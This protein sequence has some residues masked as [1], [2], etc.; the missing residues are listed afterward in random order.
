LFG[1]IIKNP[2]QKKEGIMRIR[3]KDCYARFEDFATGIG[4]WQLVKKA[5]KWVKPADCF[6]RPA[7]VTFEIRA[8]KLTCSEKNLL[9]FCRLHKYRAGYIHA[10]I[11]NTWYGYSQ[12]RTSEMSADAFRHEKMAEVAKSLL[13]ESIRYRLGIWDSGI[14]FGLNGRREVVIYI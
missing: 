4:E 13:E 1:L 14:N 2:K 10:D 11:A 6:P 3:A 9:R 5:Y 7:R 8:G 12:Q